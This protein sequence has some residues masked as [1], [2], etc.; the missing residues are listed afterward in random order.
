MEIQELQ[1]RTELQRL[2]ETF[3]YLGKF[4]HKL[5]GINQPLRQL[6]QKDIV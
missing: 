4:I 2:T 6:L 3:N 1:N 5:S